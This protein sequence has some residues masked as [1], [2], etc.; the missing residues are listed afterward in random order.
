[1][2]P[3][4]C[5][6]QEAAALIR[7]VD[8]IGMGLGPANPHAFLAALSARDDFEDLTLGGALVL[9]LFDVFSKPTVHYRSGFFGPAERFYAATGANVELVPAG[10]RQFGRILELMAPRVMVAQASV[11][12]E[13]GT[14]SLSLHYGAT[15]DALR[16]AGR[17]PERV[18]MIET[19]PHLPVTRALEGYDNTLDLSEIDV[20]IE[21]DEQPFVLAEVPTSDIDEQIALHALELIEDGS[22][23]QTGIGSIP[24]MVATKLAEGSKGGFGI[25]SEMLTDGI[26]RLHKAGKVT[27]DAKGIFEG[28]SV[29]TFALGS[30]ELYEW[31][32]HNDEVA[33]APVSVVNDPTI[34]SDNVNFVSINGAISVDLYGQ[35]VADCIDGRQISGVGGHEDFVSGAELGVDDCSLV[36]LESTIE[37]NGERRSRIQPVLP[38][39]SVVSTPRHHTGVIVTEFGAA[40]L[41]G[42]TV[43]E[44]AQA[45][46][47]IAHPDFRDELRS[48]AER[49]GRP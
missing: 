1:M 34:I 4:R 30:A 24:T 16:A 6:A 20:L 10:F 36:C 14:V 49:L 35:I 44:R 15:A 37:L 29:T 22:T 12:D 47:E 41:A 42:L 27:N 48:A 17:D 38:A 25:H 39:G 33:F 43:T 18:L 7:P 5:S 11:P 8:T 13:H 45:L 28:V 31:L 2:A 40:D 3:L 21:A 32:D 26:M 19:S 9:G 23:L 46:A